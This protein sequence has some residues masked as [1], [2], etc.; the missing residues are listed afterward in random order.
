[1]K[2]TLI[3][4]SILVI[5]V[6]SCTFAK[7]TEY[8]KNKAEIQNINNE[9]LHYQNST[10]QINTIISLMNKA[11]ELNKNNNIS[12]NE[13]LEFI[14]NETNSIK[15]YLEAMSSNNEELVQIPMEKLMLNEKAGSEKVML[16]FS[17]TKFEMT[18]K[19]YHQKTNQIKKIVFS[20][21]IN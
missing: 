3:L 5:A 16:A 21:K 6:V 1:M 18:E 8:S 13:N 10:V 2:K 15:I 11:I 12:Q 14:E 4:I 17:D 20:E 9:F 7:Y 19:E